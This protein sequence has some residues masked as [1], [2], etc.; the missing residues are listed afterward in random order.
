MPTRSVIRPVLRGVVR[1]VVSGEAGGGGGATLAFHAATF[2]PTTFAMQAQAV[3]TGTP[4]FAV[5]D[6]L[7]LPDYEG[8]YR[9]T[10]EDTA[11]WHGARQVTNLVRYSE[12]LDDVW[13]TLND[14]TLVGGATDPE[15]GTS[16]YTLTATTGTVNGR[17]WGKLNGINIPYIW[18]AVSSI[19]I[20]RVS[21]T[22]IIRMPVGRNFNW[23]DITSAVSTNWQ[24]ISVSYLSSPATFSSFGI[25]LQT[26]G[27]SVEIWRPQAED[28]TGQTNKNP[29]E[30]VPTS[31]TAASAYYANENGNT[32][33]SN[34]VTEAAGT[35]LAEVPAL[36]SAPALTNLL[37]YS[38]DL[39]N[40]AW[41]LGSNLTS[42]FNQRGLTGEA[43]S[44]TLLTAT[45]PG[46]L[47]ANWVYD[48]VTLTATGRH[49][50]RIIIPKDSDVSRFPWLRFQRNSGEIFFGRI[51]TSTG[52]FT[53]ESDAS[54]TGEA[55][56]TEVGDLWHVHLSI[57]SA[58]D[59]GALRL[60][61][62]PGGYDAAS[63]GSPAAGSL[64]V[65]NAAIYHG[66]T[67]AEV[68]GTAP[69]ITA[70]ST[71]SVAATVTTWPP[72]AAGA[73]SAFYLE[74]MAF[75]DADTNAVVFSGA[76]PATANRLIV[77]SAANW[78]A[79]GSTTPRTSG[80][81]AWDKLGAVFSQSSNG[82]QINA[83]GTYG[84]AAVYNQPS[85]IYTGSTNAAAMPTPRLVRNI[86]RY[87]I[88]DYQEG[89]DTI[90]GLMA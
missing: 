3:G 89:K 75:T 39:T 26:S 28:L 27:D 48:D 47:S 8:I 4:T 63:G 42:A 5:D 20:R 36:Y 49:T 88:A 22:G 33:S 66:K 76:W 54:G 41:T 53:V 80:A 56:V 14:A 29:G 79:Q 10:D 15:G 2:N 40:A 37:T 71:V 86:R 32:V 55:L 21:G 23:V 6:G 83:N 11:H 59:V 7:L 68:K 9:P 85:T 13:W 60:I 74:T 72:S 16:A 65:K 64:I 62:N 31:G 25:Q 38:N 81:N 67:I 82:V 1:P 69:I 90:D 17:S 43:N 58:T 34:V 24:R 77:Q 57:S 51:N 87:E 12:A 70:G 61:I 50:A 30:Y 84:S 35:P 46:A 45:T 52:E 78:Q 18:D 44:A 73:E 19:W